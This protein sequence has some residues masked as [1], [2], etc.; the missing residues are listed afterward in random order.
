M[1]QIGKSCIDRWEARLFEAD[2]PH[3]HNLRP[4]DG[5]RY[6][7]RSESG[8][9]PQ[10]YINRLEAAAACEAS[11]KRLCTLGEWY[12]ACRGKE[13]RTFPYG[14]GEKKGVC[15]A[16][17]PHLLAKLF[18]ND[19]HRWT[20]ESFNDPRLD[21]EPGFLAKSA[22]YAG[23]QSSF[24][25]YDQVGNL[26]EWV[27]DV[28]EPSLERKLPLR[29]DIRAKLEK[30]H[31]HGIFMGGFYSTTNEHG[32]GCGFVTIGH[33]PKYHDYST[34]FRCCKNARAQPPSQSSVPAPGPSALPQKP[35]R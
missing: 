24:G 33:E 5:V 6:A 26:H 3:P 1:A 19:P 29:D 34:G 22:D 8:V 17:K 2:T 30:N 21:I 32:E 16:S 14:P 13:R 12:T 25:V 11:D 7:A 4:K 20:Y 10:A 27:S 28:V 31:G 15:N 18:G 35:L 9:F 23:C